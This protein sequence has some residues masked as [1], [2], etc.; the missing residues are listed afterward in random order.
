MK[1]TKN[2]LFLILC[3]FSTS[4]K[5]Q[6]ITVDDNK[7]AQQ[8]VENVLVKST[9]ANVSNFNA[10]GDRFTPGR[11]SYGYF[12]ADT[13]N[14]PLRE[15]V[16]LATST[17]RAARG[18][19]TANS[20]GGNSEWKG[21]SDLDLALG[22]H[23]INATVLEFDFVPL[24]SAISFNY[25]FASNEYQ[26]DFSCKYSDAFAFLIKEKGTTDNYKN[27]AVIPGTT[28]PVSSKNIHPTIIDDPSTPVPG[29]VE[30]GCP[31]INETLFGNYNTITSS[32]P[33][34]YNGQ[35]KTLNAYA[36]VVIGKTYHIKLVI[37]D[38]N[39]ELYDS[40]V[41][42]EAGSFTA[43]ID[44]GPDR[45]AATNNPLCYGDSFTIDTKLPLTYAYEWYKDGST[46]P[47][48]GENKPSL[49][50]TTP[51]TYKVK[52]PLLPAACTA[53]DEIKIEYAPQIVLNNSTLYQCDDNGDG[54]SVFNLTKADNIIKNNNPS[55]TKLV[56]YK[57]MADAQNETNPILNTTSYVNSVPNETLVAKVSNAFN[58]FDYAQ[59]NLVISNNAIS[60]QNPIQ[61]CDNDA[62]QDG[63]TQFD[64]NAKV[65]PQVIN[66]LPSGLVVE[67]YLNQTDAIAQ[68]NQLPNL[69][70]N[71]IANQQT[72][73]ARIVNGTDCYKITPETLV[74]NVF[75]PNDFQDE[76]SFICENSTET[77][78]I[79]SGFTSYL[80]SNGSTTNTTTVIAP[81]E[82]TVTVT[83]SA[84]CQKTKKYIVNPS[85]IGTITNAAVSDFAG[86]D[87]SV[88]ISY[89]GKGDYE[90][91]LDGNLYQ[92]SPVFNGL[93][94]GMYWAT[95]NDK[96]GCGISAPYQIY[97]LDYPRFFTPN[98]D[99][100]N[101]TWKIKNL[102]LLPKSSITIFDRYGKLLKQLNEPNTGWNGFYLGRELPSD[103]YWFALTFEDGKTIKGHFSLKR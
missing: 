60:P 93:S 85:S 57:S 14:F 10:T 9:C 92:D 21:D 88:T 103:D 41:F 39:S 81:G 40:A 4:V 3:I 61:S 7:T 67:Y 89:S 6:F 72:I 78:T 46:I 91:S 11:N 73:Y 38:D 44:L 1:G 98:N 62:T 30:N 63:L 65:T 59:L 87:N 24:T 66:G 86:N 68:K 75:N 48:P 31:A 25:I 54:I 45:T 58:C 56:Y 33:I 74:V 16:I 50:V 23:S 27:I 32:S 100:F 53:E 26:K 77:L 82:Y 19:Y 43:D 29:P 52:V 28:T 36:D 80:W 5:A 83:N 20:G 79:Q 42:L 96:N 34:N 15:G 95:T 37:A 97:V 71:T 18:P 70:T 84:G 94:P 101:D 35:T 64:L 12:N 99:G 47:M 13:S 22:I 2:L 8:L 69:F 90:F 76:S 17:S 55:L 51:G 102:D 49:T